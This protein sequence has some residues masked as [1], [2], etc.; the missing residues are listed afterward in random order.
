MSTSETA[1]GSGG[2]AGAQAPQPVA[3]ARVLAIFGGLMLAMLLAALDQTIVATAL[4]TIV[5]DL[6]GLEHISW[7]TTAYLLAST[8]STPLYGK[9]G[10]LYG[11]KRVFQVA[12]VIFLAGSALCGL[13]QSM[14]ELI[15]F[16]ALQ[17]LGG[18]GLI[19]GAQAII[20]DV[21]SPRERGRYQGFFGAVF[22]VASVAGPLLGG[23]FV[24]HLSWEWIFYINLPIGAIALV[25]IAAV[26]PRTDVHRQHAIDWL[27]TGLM[28][29]GVSCLILFLSLGG[30]TQPW[31]APA[32][33]A[34]ALG[35]V[36]L[37]TLF[38][39]VERRAQEPILP[40]RLFSN[41][42]FSVTSGIGFI[43]GF[44][45]FGA[46]TFLPLFLQ[47]VNGAS[48]T[49]SGLEMLP[50]MAGVLVTSI[51]SGQ[52]IART[53]RYKRYP[54]AGT[55]TMAI[56]FVLLAQMDASTSTL[57]RSLSMLV[58]GLGLGMTMQVLVLAVQ[59]AVDY[60][61]LGTATSGATFFRSI[62][63]SFG[64]AIFGAIFA[65]RLTDT[66]ADHFPDGLPPALAGAGGGHGGGVDPAAIH[67]LPDAIRSGF[68]DGYAE[69]LQTVFWIAVPI[70][71]VA[72]A[73]TWLLREVPLRRTV[74]SSG[75]G[76]S[77]A[78]PKPDT[79]YDEIARAVSVLARRDTRRRIYERLAARAGVELSPAAVW[80]LARVAELSPI[81][82]DELSERTGVPRA[83]LRIALAELEMER[84][85][86]E[87]G[88]DA[89]PRSA[90][91]GDPG[92]A[93]DGV[94]VEAA[95]PGE[96]PLVLTPA[97]SAVRDRLLAARRDR[98]EELLDGW[99][100]E[101]HE[102]LAAMLTR[103]AGELA[104][105][106]GEAPHAHAVP[107]RP[108]GSTSAR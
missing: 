88:A 9:L 42:V 23:F 39:L 24:E 95:G 40:L 19:V 89:G 1:P 108:P 55:F 13:S 100:P 33:I 79:S 26:L 75:L 38:V 80:L 72:F 56:G 43:V 30:T 28:A 84:L 52:I 54:I 107:H 8:A 92:W 12:I 3:Q 29:S 41:R 27:G 99:S 60:R 67:E 65:N 101:Q 90:D 74:E 94:G 47:V 66:I 51:A 15:L 96:V 5:G 49:G 97:G 73:L 18:G 70:A 93:P 71:L 31:D 63:G 6:G 36:V 87:C 14:L 98:L 91:A 44:G 16:R 103:L 77:F 59:N 78:V 20:G 2:G 64:V 22:G 82:V 35:G 106:P 48:A 34:L 4:P 102:E 45:M 85:V 104:E 21:V 105:Q 10:D 69:A 57:Q 32:S 81:S 62:G 37:T 50:L 53:G 83:R 25:V 58:L 61:D 17:G 76:E 68:V 46:I 86:E 7:V 11:R